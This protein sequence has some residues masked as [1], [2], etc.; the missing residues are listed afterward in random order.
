M[1][2]KEGMKIVSDGIHTEV[3]LN[4]VKVEGLREIEFSQY[5]DEAPT[6]RLEVMPFYIEKGG[7]CV[8]Y[9]SK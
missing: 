5:I 8:N 3:Y 2:I 1:E 4:G 6:L 7:K 9:D